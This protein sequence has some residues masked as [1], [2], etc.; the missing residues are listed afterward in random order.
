MILKGHLFYRQ[1]GEDRSSHQ[2]YSGWTLVT[3]HNFDGTIEKIFEI[4]CNDTPT[5]KV[6]AL[7][8]FLMETDVYDERN[9]LVF[10]CGFR[11]SCT[12]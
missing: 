1:G 6:G 12:S 9:T 5:V 10:L 7:D 3:S 11:C 8:L 4:S 2:N